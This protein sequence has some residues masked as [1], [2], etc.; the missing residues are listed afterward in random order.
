MTGDP[1]PSAPDLRAQPRVG[2]D[3]VWSLRPV[4]PL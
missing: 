4:L 1:P 2:I 3:G